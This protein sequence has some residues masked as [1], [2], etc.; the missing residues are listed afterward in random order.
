[1]TD[2][3]RIGEFHVEP[4]LNTVTGPAGPTRLEPKVMQVLVCLAAHAGQVVS[5]ERLMRSVWPDTFVGD[6]VLTRCISELRRVFGDDA[7][8]PRYIQTIPKSGYRLIAGLFSDAGQELV[9]PRHETAEASGPT[10]ARVSGHTLALILTGTALLAGLVIGAWWM[11]MARPGSTGSPRQPALTQLAA[12]PLRSIAVLPLENLSRDPEQDIF[13]DGMTEALITELGKISVLRVISRQSITQY[14]ATK[15][16]APQIAH[17]LNVEAVVEGSVLRAG[18]QVRISVQLVEAFP[19][20]HL[21]ADTYDRAL[22]DVLTV[23]SEIARAVAREVRATL[24]PQEQGLLANATPVNPEAY[25]SYLHGRYLQSEEGTPD[26][27]TRA[28]EDFERAISLEPGW[29]L[30]YCGIADSHLGRGHLA[31]VASRDAFPAAKSAALKAQQLN[32]NAA[33]AHTALADVYSLYEWNWAD[34]ERAYRRGLELNP[35][36]AEAHFRYAYFLVAMERVEEALEEA[37][38]VVSLNPAS[39][40]ANSGVAWVLYFTDR[41]DEAIRQDLHTLEIAPNYALAHLCLGLA[42]EQK[43]DYSRAL[44]ELKRAVELSRDRQLSLFIAHAH[45]VSGDSTEARRLLEDFKQPSGKSYVDPWAIAVIYAGLGERNQAI[46]WL[47]KAYQ[48]RDHDLVLAKVWPQFDPLHSDP[49]FQDLLRRMN[50][51]PDTPRQ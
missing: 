13:T 40:R 45:A 35:G 22:R 42:Y 16:S 3:F 21:W 46:E 48:V 47:Q 50:L 9:A 17:E 23:H 49:P 19:E 44:V 38:N 20:R 5:K 15:K 6:D 14:K 11:A 1:L 43:R 33:C 27:F 34:A 32:E 36:D 7:K 37:R 26:S 18:D 30:P 41:Y 31:A 51:P 12:K 4:S 39:P 10:V 24:T 8:E 25:E 28:I 29:A 2:S